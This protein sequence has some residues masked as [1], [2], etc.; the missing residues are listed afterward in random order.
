MFVGRQTVLSSTTNISLKRRLT[1]I[2][3][4]LRQH[5]VTYINF[6][7]RSFLIKGQERFIHEFLVVFNNIITYSRTLYVYLTSS[8]VKLILVFT[9]T[10]YFRPLYANTN[11]Y[12]HIP[13]W[14]ICYFVL[15][16][17]KTL[18]EMQK[19]INI[20]ISHF[21]RQVIQVNIPTYN[22]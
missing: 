17:Y 22:M 15:F 2:A 4:W 20:Y 16:L 7:R 14:R 3:S 21:Y 9:I 1:C 11:K 12:L 13:T 10:R 6:L 18:I 5:V 19:K 8:L